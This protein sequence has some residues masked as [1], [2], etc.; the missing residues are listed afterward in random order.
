MLNDV[1]A[2]HRTDVSKHPDGADR[3]V[4]GEGQLFCGREDADVVAVPVDAR[5]ER[6]L[7]EVRPLREQLHLLR[8]Q[9]R[10]VVDDHDGVPVAVDDEERRRVGSHVVQR[11]R[12]DRT[13]KRHFTLDVDDLVVDEV[14]CVM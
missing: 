9:T 4:A 6:G 12:L 13:A 7:G 3:G 11:R 5:D 2:L 10:G 14:V 8:R 1:G